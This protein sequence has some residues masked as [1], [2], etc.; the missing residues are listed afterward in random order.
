MTQPN[1]PDLAEKLAVEQC[2]R[3]EA[4]HLVDAMFAD[5]AYDLIDREQVARHFARH[6][7]STLRAPPAPTEG[8]ELHFPPALSAPIE[9]VEQIGYLVWNSMTPHSK[10][11]AKLPLT[12]ADKRAGYLEQ[13]VYSALSARPDEL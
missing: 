9:V 5:E 8:D 13:P 4:D 3:D 12:D 10:E 6:R 7:L 11:F 2:D 1:T